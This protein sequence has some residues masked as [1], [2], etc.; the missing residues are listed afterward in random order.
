MR[1][2]KVGEL[3]LDFNLYPRL[4]VSAQ[5]ATYLR[6]AIEAGATIPP[7]VICA[8]SLRVV[9]GF[10]RCRAYSE[11]YGADHVIDVIAKKYRTEAEILLDAMRLNSSHGAN[12][13]RYDRVHCMLLSE[14]LELTLDQIGTA[15][16]MTPESL[17]ELRE[18]RVAMT[19]SG[20][21]LN[22]TPLK[23]SIRHMS[24]K[25]LTA[26]QVAT[27]A[28]LSGMSAGFH[29]SQL[30]LLINNDL[31]NTS[32]ENLMTKLKLLGTLIRQIKP[33]AAA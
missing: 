7:V 21:R 6:G 18:G 8:K 26:E 4:T 27:N 19:L 14:K 28:K 15:L 17:S 10:H 20:K 5:H 13:T 32:D 24:G 16:S 25:T 3:V 33:T 23:Q 29:V 30:I 12:L 9:D 11:L 1:Q 2:I 22:P 31:L